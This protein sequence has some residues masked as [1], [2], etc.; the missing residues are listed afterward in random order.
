MNYSGIFY[1]VMVRSR[2]RYENKKAR[3]QVHGLGLGENG[4]H[5]PQEVSC[6]QGIP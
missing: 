1:V 5:G 6:S 3:Q 2:G 4:K